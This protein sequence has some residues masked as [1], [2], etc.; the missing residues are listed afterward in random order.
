MSKANNQN[1]KEQIKELLTMYKGEGSYEFIK[2]LKCDE[3]M[4]KHY[5]D[6][7]K[8][9]KK[10]Y[11]YL[12]NPLPKVKVKYI[13]IGKEPSTPWAGNEKDVAL[14]KVM[15]NGYMNFGF[16]DTNY[17]KI[18]IMLMAFQSVFGDKAFYLTDLSKCAINTNDADNLG[19]KDGP[20]HRYICCAPFL[21]WELNSLAAKNSHIFLVGKTDFFNKWHKREGYGKGIDE[22]NSFQK[23]LETK[24]KIDHIS[25]QRIYQIPHYSIRF[26]C[27]DVTL[28]LL[29]ND[30]VEVKNVEENIRSNFKP[31]LQFCK[32]KFIFSLNIRENIEKLIKDNDDKITKSKITDSLILLF[33]LYKNEFKLAKEQFPEN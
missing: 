23:F 13:F 4:C 25:S 11:Q 29:S 5:R 18:Y 7:S 27:P 6:K 17:L 2:E 8:E 14:K 19:K 1:T 31:L 15:E 12:P 9:E 30:K 22:F 32:D 20:D 33:L 24:V 10:I 3:G 26:P 28:R 21:N 16:G